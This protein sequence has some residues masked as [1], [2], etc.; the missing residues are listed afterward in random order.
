MDNCDAKFRGLAGRRDINIIPI[1][2]DLPRVSHEVAGKDV[3]KRGFP[4]SVFSH[5]GQ[6]FMT[7]KV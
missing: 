3:H 2:H 6:N 7:I 1:D 5:Q 4:R